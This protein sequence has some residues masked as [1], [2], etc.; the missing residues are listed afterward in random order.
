MK[1][2]AVLLQ[3][4]MHLLI[5][6]DFWHDVVLLYYQGGVVC[7]D[8]RLLLTVYGS[9]CQLLAECMRCH[10]LADELQFLIHSTSVLVVG[11]VLF[12]HQARPIDP[13]IRQPGFDLPRQ[14]WTLLNRF[15]TGQG[16]CRACCPNGAGL[17]H[18]RPLWLWSLADNESHC[19]HVPVD[20]VRWW[21]H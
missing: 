21:T 4:N 16:P 19:Q 14:T 3:V 11:S 18:I 7:H 2:I 8:V 15:C 1:F 5:E 12:C 10:W 6:L 17:Y 13:T 9:V 20:K